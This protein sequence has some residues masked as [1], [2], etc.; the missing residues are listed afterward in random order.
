LY[1]AQSQVGYHGEE[2]SV[3]PAK[4]ETQIYWSNQIGTDL[5][6]VAVVEEKAY[7]TAD[8]FV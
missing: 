2:E 6:V 1:W 8:C 4:N 3:C 5:T 7:P